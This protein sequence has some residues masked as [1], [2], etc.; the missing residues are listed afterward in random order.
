MAD[1]QLK[2]GQVEINPEPAKN[3]L[4]R[5]FVTRTSPLKEKA[6]G[7]F[8]GLLE[9][10]FENKLDE[11]FLDNL[12]KKLKDNYYQQSE[13]IEEINIENIFEQALK[14]TNSELNELIKKEAGFDLNN[15]N[16]V[17]AVLK[18][19]KLYFAPV[20]NAQIFLIH[21]LGDNK[22][23]I[24]DI[25]ETTKNVDAYPSANKLFSNIVNGEINSQDS[26]LIANSNFLDYLSL[27]KAKQIIT[28]LPAGNA[29]EQLR[30]LL[31]NVNNHNVFG[32]LI[33]EYIPLID[34]I[35][36]TTVK[37]IKDDSPQDSMDDLV[38]TETATEKLLS[39]SLGLNL[40][41]KIK[42]LASLFK[43][44]DRKLAQKA[45]NKGS[46]GKSQGILKIIFRQL[47]RA[48]I[49]IG[50][51]FKGLLELLI[52]P[53]RS[54]EEKHKLD[55]KTNNRIQRFFNLPRGQKIMIISA[56]IFVILFSQVIV[57]LSKRQSNKVE[58][59]QYDTIVSQIK[60]KHD[61]AEAS[62]IYQDDDRAREL[63]IEARDLI[64]NLPQNSRQKRKDFLALAEK[65][66]GLLEKTKKV[67]N[68]ENLNIIADFADSN[69][70]H[71]NQLILND[72]KLY[73]YSQ[74]D[75]SIY[76]LDLSNNQ[77]KNLN[78][79]TSQVGHLQF[80][81]TLGNGTFLFYHDNNGFAKFTLADNIINP[82]TVELTDQAKVEYFT[83][84]NR[85]LYLLDPNNNQLYKHEP[86]T[87]G[88]AKG[89][90]WL[91]TTLSINK[92]VSFAID[93]NV[94]ILQN[95]GQIL[96]FL[97]GQKQDFNP[98]VLET[99]LN[100]PTK[101]KTEIDSDYLYILDPAN[102]RLV[103]LDKEGKLK[104]Q[105]TSEQFTNLKDFIIKEAD[106]KIYLLNNSQVI[107]IPIRH[108]D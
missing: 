78:S 66:E 34:K 18:D 91:K 47:L 28:D 59:Q 71:P 20:G 73:S 27:D 94:Y 108:V 83:I 8:F 57:I 95:N 7:K 93:G 106:N 40:G 54:A 82:T 76:E 5:V 12:V 104:G 29:A 13:N 60:E 102:K 99:P 23:S 80:G 85:R 100:K 33:T 37:P 97:K 32:A 25:L 39:P 98:A 86:T 22:H 61:S 96:K 14:K 46:Y 52:K 67:I 90:A 70:L 9:A 42:G 24:I 51:L 75:N 45:Y 31:Q 35:K 10:R 15:F 58:Q 79:I 4:I 17:I 56:L 81:T 11:D 87:D 48:I 26:L 43:T 103:V 2:I 92:A 89:T 77:I 63:L 50:Y 88:F 1:N 55:P 64:N 21:S 72:N 3:W 19:Q 101:I 49:M 65:N 36:Q 105:Y 84:Y 44:K 68:L 62:H 16:A 53:R 41:Q 6:L 107:E 38:D 69:L 74:T 30:N